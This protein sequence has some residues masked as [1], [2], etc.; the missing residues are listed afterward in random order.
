MCTAL[1]ACCQSNGL[2]V[3]C[4]VSDDGFRVRNFYVDDLIST[5]SHLAKK[6]WVFCYIIQSVYNLL[7][8]DQVEKVVFKYKTRTPGSCVRWFLPVRRYASAVFATATCLSVCPSVMS[9]YCVKTKKASV[10]ISSPLLSRCIRGLGI[11]SREV[12][13]F[14]IF[15]VLVNIEIIEKN[16]SLSHC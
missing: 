1:V 10:M 15:K 5:A 3:D 6:T 8:N 2:H 16:F 7:R 4:N 9:R 13:V 11:S 14:K 12:K